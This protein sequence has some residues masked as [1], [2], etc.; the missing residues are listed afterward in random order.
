MSSRALAGVESI[1]EE[2]HR[3]QVGRAA[4]AQPSRDERAMR[5]HRMPA[6]VT[7]AHATACDE[8]ARGRAGEI[9]AGLATAMQQ[10][11]VVER[12]D[13]REAR[14]DARGLGIVRDV[15]CRAP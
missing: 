13:Q 11:R 5:G 10:I 9:E 15:A 4:G 8:R 3:E 6:P 12:G 14:I 7:R 1:D 2:A